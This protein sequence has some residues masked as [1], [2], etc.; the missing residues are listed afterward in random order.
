MN[1]LGIGDHIGEPFP[2]RPLLPRP[3]HADTLGA[4]HILRDAIAHE[5]RVV[6]GNLQGVQRCLEDLGVRFADADIEGVCA[7]VSYGE[8]P[9]ALGTQRLPLTFPL[10]F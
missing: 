4:C 9:S 6:G 3:S 10:E 8:R 7:T 5:Y 2:I 1:D